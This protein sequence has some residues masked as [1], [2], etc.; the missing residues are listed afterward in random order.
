MNSLRYLFALLLSVATLSLAAKNDEEPKEKA[1][2]FGGAAIYVDA[3]GPIMKA[4]GSAGSNMEAGVRFNLR[5]KFF[6]VAEIGIGTCDRDGAENTNH[7]HTTA[8]FIRVGMDYNINKKI[9]GNRFFAGGRYGWSSFKFDF[10]NDQLIDPVWN[11][12]SPLRVNG[13]SSTYHWIELVIGLETK[14]WRFIRLGYTARMK[15]T[16]AQSG[17]DLGEPYYIPGFGR[18]GQPFGGTFYVAFDVGK[19]ARSNKK[20]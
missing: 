9:N 12:L 6:P 13:Q 2:L 17:T 7:F 1:P 10:T 3:V 4:F 16:V 15:F 18:N 14:L 19:S 11:T 5:E 8:P 20:K